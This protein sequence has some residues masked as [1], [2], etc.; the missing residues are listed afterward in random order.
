M[1]WIWVASGFRLHLSPCI[2]DL[3]KD[4]LMSFFISDAISLAFSME[5]LALFLDICFI[6]FNAIGPIAPPLLRSKG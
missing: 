4:M 5:N 6:A 1:L 3:I 2:R